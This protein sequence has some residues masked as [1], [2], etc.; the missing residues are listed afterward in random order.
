MMNRAAQEVTS[1]QRPSGDGSGSKE[2]KSSRGGAFRTQQQVQVPVLLEFVLCFRTERVSV[3]RIG[4][5]DTRQS[6]HLKG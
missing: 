4:P 5:R 6:F 2:W 1:E 3:S